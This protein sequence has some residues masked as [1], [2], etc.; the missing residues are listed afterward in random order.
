MDIAARFVDDVAILDL[1]GRLAVGADEPAVPLRSLIRT[2]LAQGC[3][4][5]ALNLSRLTS[6]DAWGLGELAVAHTTVRRAGGELALVAPTPRVRKML[7]VTRLVEVLTVR[8]EEV[9]TAR[10]ARRSTPRTVGTLAH[11]AWA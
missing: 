1:E 8:D 6:I 2:L 9:Q 11:S 4:R 10:A 3:I 5:F 7:A